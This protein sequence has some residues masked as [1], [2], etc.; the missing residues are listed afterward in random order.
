[1]D[2]L[3]NRALEFYNHSLLSSLSIQRRVFLILFLSVIGV[4]GSLAQPLITSVKASHL[5]RE[6]MPCNQVID[7]TLLSLNLDSLTLQEIREW[8]TTNYRVENL[9][10]HDMNW[11]SEGRMYYPDR[12]SQTVTSVWMWWESM[13]PTAAEVVDCLGAPD[14][15]RTQYD[16]DRVALE[17]GYDVRLELWYLDEGIVVYGRYP[18]NTLKPLFS[19]SDSLMDTLIKAKAGTAEEVADV[20]HNPA[21]YPIYTRDISKAEFLRSLKPWPDAWEEIEVE[22]NPSN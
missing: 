14:L 3:P 7:D 11:R 17:A 18:S 9:R 15:Y 5:F 10:G 16:V 2:P 1:M 6:P 19:P 8:I 21:S 20:I 22:I 13:Q 4:I 12:K